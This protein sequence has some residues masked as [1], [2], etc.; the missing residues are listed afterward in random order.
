[1]EPWRFCF[2]KKKG[3]IRNPN[4]CNLGIME[5]HVR[6]WTEDIWAEKRA[7]YW[8]RRTQISV[9][10]AEQ[11]VL[12]WVWGRGSTLPRRTGCSGSGGGLGATDAAQYTWCSK[13]EE[14]KNRKPKLRYLVSER[15]GKFWAYSI[16][17]TPSLRNEPQS[18]CMKRSKAAA[19]SFP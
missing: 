7:R 3:K 13:R 18:G 15:R 6:D 19:Q 10:W 17:P 12:V 14:G 2:K 9:S 8:T 11:R 1:M 16:S 5:L 4:I